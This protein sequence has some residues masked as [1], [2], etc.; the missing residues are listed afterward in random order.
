M[1]LAVI[2]WMDGSTRRQEALGPFEVHEDYSHLEEISGALRE[3]HADHERIECIDTT[4]FAVTPAGL[5]PG[6]PSQEE[7]T[8]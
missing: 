5:A 7:P 4:L 8:P 6:A 2:A 3:W 1:I